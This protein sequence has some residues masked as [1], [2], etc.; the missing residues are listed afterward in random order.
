MDASGALADSQ[1]FNSLV[2][3]FLD[4]L[5]TQLLAGDTERFLKIG[6]NE[7]IEFCDQLSFL[8]AGAQPTRACRPLQRVR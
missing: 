1:D 4:A 5:R 2:G 6:L 8:V 7:S 3:D